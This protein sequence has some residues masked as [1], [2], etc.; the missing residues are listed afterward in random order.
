MAANM[1]LSMAISGM[2][3]EIYFVIFG[4]PGRFTVIHLDPL[5]CGR[6]LVIMLPS[7][8]K[9]INAPL[10][11]CAWRHPGNSEYR[12]CLEERGY[13]TSASDEI[14]YKRLLAKTKL[15]N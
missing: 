11:T 15:F 8:G 9:E 10:R 2:W 5:M 1:S 4:N 12:K 13:L 6:S 7:V 14:E 3:K